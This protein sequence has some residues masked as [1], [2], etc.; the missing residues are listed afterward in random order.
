MVWLRTSRSMRTQTQA[1]S[2]SMFWTMMLV[3]F[4]AGYVNCR[5]TSSFVF[6]N[7]NSL[8]L[9]QNKKSKILVQS[10][11]QD[12]EKLFRESTNLFLKRNTICREKNSKKRGE[13]LR[14]RVIS[15]V[16]ISGGDIVS[17]D[18]SASSYSSRNTL[19][20]TGGLLLILTELYARMPFSVIT[21]P[22]KF[23]INTILSVAF[24][25]AIAPFAS[26]CLKLSPMPTILKLRYQEDVGGL[27]LLPY[28]AM[29]TL[30]FVL[31]VYGKSLFPSIN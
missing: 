5:G 12:E 2:I 24:W 1:S 9:H 31:T 10:K 27:P 29:C 18:D 14:S 30:T 23:I 8:S 17:Q 11:F 6:E 26:I 28:S 21:S 3:I 25:S 22:M 7:R 19:L 4:I 15:S 20:M 13:L 16:S